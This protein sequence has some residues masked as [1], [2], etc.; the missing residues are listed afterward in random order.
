M[1][2]SHDPH[3]LARIAAR[4][5]YDDIATLDNAR[6]YFAANMMRDEPLNTRHDLR[7]A[8]SDDIADLLHNANLADLIPAADDMTDD[9]YDSLMRFLLDSDDFL[10]H[11]TLILAH[12]LAI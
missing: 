1:T 10:N 7:D 12:R 9:D 5:Y 3:A 11:L 2:N 8:L 6:D 4:S